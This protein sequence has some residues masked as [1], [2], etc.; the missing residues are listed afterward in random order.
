MTWGVKGSQCL[1]SHP[2]AKKVHLEPLRRK[3][4]FSAE[5]S[6][7]CKGNPGAVGRLW[8]KDVVTSSRF[9]DGLFQ[10]LVFPTRRDTVTSLND[11]YFA[12]RKRRAVGFLCL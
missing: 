7:M 1:S 8:T 9:F 12:S 2:E 3:D 11:F 4:E 5:G 6:T 10:L